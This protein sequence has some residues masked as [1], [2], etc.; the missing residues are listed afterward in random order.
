M[1]LCPRMS[2]RK[3]C[4]KSKSTTPKSEAHQELHRVVGLGSVAFPLK[5][6]ARVPVDPAGLF[7]PEP[8]S[9]Y[10]LGHQSDHCSD[11][12]ACQI[13]RANSSFHQVL[14]KR[15]QRL[16]GPAACASEGVLIGHVDLPLPPQSS[17]DYCL[18]EV[19]QFSM[20][21]LQ[22]SRKLL[23]RVFLDICYGTRKFL[24]NAN[25][26]NLQRISESSRK[27]FEIPTNT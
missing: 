1:H 9:P 5:N 16:Q 15:E 6:V 27:C 22:L 25:Y 2:W 4:L 11:P 23:Y 19:C 26:W 10:R 21:T 24:R 20:E 17:Q 18:C 14:R 12:G 8:N 7:T 13:H 3:V